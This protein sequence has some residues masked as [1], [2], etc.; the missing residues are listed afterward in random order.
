MEAAPVAAEPVAEPVAAKPATPEED[1][2]ST[3]IEVNDNAL[4]DFG[5]KADPVI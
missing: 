4:K 1:V 3:V 2:N 5:Q